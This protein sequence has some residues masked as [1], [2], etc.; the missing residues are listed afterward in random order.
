ML[1]RVSPLPTQNTHAQEM[2]ASAKPV[3]AIQAV[4]IDMTQ[5]PIDAGTDAHLLHPARPFAELQAQSNGFWG[6]GGEATWR[7]RRHLC[8]A[9]TAGVYC[10]ALVGL[11]VGCITGMQYGTHRANAHL[12]VALG[13]GVTAGLSVA[14]IG[15]GGLLDSCAWRRE[16]ARRRKLMGADDAPTK[17]PLIAALREAVKEYWHKDEDSAHR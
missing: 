13:F 1:S 8:L 3:H 9:L 17:R 11:V 14:S 2:S 6:E 5:G 10:S 7:S 4:A 12:G 16:G 15:V